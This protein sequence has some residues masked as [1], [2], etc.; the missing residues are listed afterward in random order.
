MLGLKRN[1]V[2]LVPHTAVWAD[3]FEITKNELSELLVGKAMD[4][5]H[6]G[7]T[8]VEKIKAKPILDIALL[9]K[10]TVVIEELVLLLATKGYEYRGNKE[11]NGGHLFIKNS[12]N[13]IRTHH[14]HI[15]E[16]HD[17]QWEDLLYFRDALRKNSPLAEEYEKLKIQLEA[18][19]SGNRL[20]YTK[21]KSKF[22]KKVIQKRQI[23]K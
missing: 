15:F 4:I 13:D 23:K 11:K 18:L 7:S 20:E 17:P 19:Y 8:S 14:L 10:D 6:I 1:T 16:S 21:G 2:K 9:V 22:I 12:G 5:Q 3:I